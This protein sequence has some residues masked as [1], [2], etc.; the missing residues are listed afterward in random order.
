M[1]ELA[2]TIEQCPDHSGKKAQETGPGQDV[3]H[4]QLAKR[5]RTAV[6]GR[7]PEVPCLHGEGLPVTVPVSD[8]VNTENQENMRDQNPTRGSD[9]P[10]HAQYQ[11]GQHE[12]NGKYSK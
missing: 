10:C 9:P 12:G 1:K 8:K 4:D 5:W 6:D 11:V 7:Q 3:A 2:I